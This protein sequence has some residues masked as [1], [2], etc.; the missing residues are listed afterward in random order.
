MIDSVQGGTVSSTP[1]GTG[2]LRVVIYVLFAIG[3]MLADHHGSYITK[4]KASLSVVVYPIVYLVEWPSRAG[5]WVSKTWVEH[6]NTIETNHRLE[7]Q[8]LQ[9]QSELS[10]LRSLQ[11]END[12]LRTLLNAAPRVQGHTLVADI[13]DIDLDPYSH[14]IAISLG[15]R[16]NIVVGQPLV[17]AS[18]VVGQVS[19]VSPLIANALMISDPSHAIPVT[20]NRTGLRGIAY[21]IGR[22]DQIELRDIPISS[23]LVVGD[24][25][26]TSGM[27]GR[28]PIGIPVGTVTDISRPDDDAFLTVLASPSA[29]LGK[30]HQVLVVWPESEA[31]SPE[32]PE[33]EQ[34][35]E[36]V[37]DGA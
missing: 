32:T 23:D 4:L 8:V 31:V 25:L 18:G 13:V 19:S 21:G 26:V 5:S 24:L 1:S 9:L 30:I 10:R 17:D 22:T 36:Q 14:Q 37:L 11:T 33:A 3:L 15:A 7:S 35:V 12:R 2:A 16:D 29:D 34:T 28:F 27:G 6:D 20:V